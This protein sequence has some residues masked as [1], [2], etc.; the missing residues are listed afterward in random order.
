[1][2]GVGEGVSPPHR[3]V[4]SERG[5]DFLKF[6]HKM[7]QIGAFWWI[8]HDLFFYSFYYYFLGLC[9]RLF[10]TKVVQCIYKVRLTE[11]K[12]AVL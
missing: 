1:M 9:I 6:R 10:T 12:K 4:G 8:L 5:C 7:M 2:W 11:N 3:W